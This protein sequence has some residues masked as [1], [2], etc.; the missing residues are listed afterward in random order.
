MERT[1][2]PEPVDADN[3]QPTTVRLAVLA[4]LGLLVMTAY[5]TR[6]C[7]SVANTTIQRELSVTSEQMG[8]VLAAFSMGYLI[9]QVP[10]GWLGTRY[11]NRM[12]LP[13]LSFLFSLATFWS[14][15]AVSVAGLWASRVALGCAQAG[16]IPCTAKVVSDWFPETQRGMTSA[17]MGSSMSVGAVVASGLT[18]ALIP[19]I[20]WR[21]VFLCYAALGCLWALGFALW[22]RDDPAAHPRTNRAER[23][24]IANRPE[25]QPHLSEPNETGE[26]SR[27]PVWLAM[28][29][30]PSL[31]AICAQA[32]FRA[33]GYIFFVTWFPAYLEKGYGVKVSEAGA[34]TMVPLTAVVGGTMLGGGL[35]DLLLR[36]TGSKWVSRSATS[37]VALT[38]CAVATLLASRAQGPLAAVLLISCGTFFSGLGNPAAWTATMDISG[39]HTSVV[40]GVMNMSGVLGG[41]LCPILL[42]HLF[43]Y[44]QR[45]D[46]D[47][48]W[49]LY[50]FGANYVAGALCWLMLNPNRSAVER[51]HRSAAT[52]FP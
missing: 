41:I 49:V 36:R 9:F 42:G 20:G 30:S 3:D 46:G 47:W 18:A 31:W 29:T 21:P 39:R 50:L 35:V 45:T 44:I 7:I 34:L 15:L 1:H 17:V 4:W 51:P 8:E 33:F 10:G 25:G 5:L 6:S 37:A 52:T 12:A 38:L 26:A 48:N 2:E 24:L 19:E 16:V 22:F 23:Q 40:F 11:G 13:L 43:S 32:F 27:G 14:A 28:L